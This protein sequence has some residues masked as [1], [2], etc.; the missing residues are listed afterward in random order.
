MTSPLA[1]CHGP[2]PILSRALTAGA[3]PTPLLLK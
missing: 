3:P 1:F 2:L